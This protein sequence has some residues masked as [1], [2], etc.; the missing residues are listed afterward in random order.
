MDSAHALA[1]LTSLADGI[2][3]LTGEI[4]DPDSPYQSAEVVRALFMAIKALEATPSKVKRSASVP[5]NA[6]ARWTEQE[7]RQLLELFDSGCDLE[8]IATRHGRT[9]AGIY[10]RLERHGRVQPGTQWRTAVNSL[11]PRP[12]A[13]APAQDP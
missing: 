9:A 5:L 8:T 4:F 13:S 11:P 3:P 2:N 6:G 12:D 7:D 1:V 10:A